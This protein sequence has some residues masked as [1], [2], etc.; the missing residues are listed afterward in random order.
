VTRD[1]HRQRVYDAEDAAFGG[2]VL[3]HPL[4]WDDAVALT[5]AVVHH[6][7]WSLLGVPSPQVLRAR[8][9]ATRSSADGNRVRLARDGQDAVTVAHELTH[10]LVANTLRTV[11][12]HG[13]EFC[14][15]LLRTIEVMGGIAARDRFRG[16]L[17]ARGVPV[18][19]W[20]GPEPPHRAPLAGTLTRTG[21]GRLRGALMLPRA[22]GLGS[23]SAE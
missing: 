1:Q 15:A 4:S 17:A 12:P 2:T 11:A 19:V 14:A 5:H 18:G 6:P 21:P 3:T 9:D 10:H 7:W 16:E 8:G 20:W 23:P 22:R 13:P